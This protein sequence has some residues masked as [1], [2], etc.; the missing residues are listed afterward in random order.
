MPLCAKQK[1]LPDF[2]A[3][4]VKSTSHFTHFEKNQD[5]HSLCIS[6]FTDSKRLG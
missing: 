4:F 3:A 1:F 5:P 2:F 6:K